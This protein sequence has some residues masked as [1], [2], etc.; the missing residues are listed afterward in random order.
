MNGQ[1]PF[2]GWSVVGFTF[3][4]Q[5]VAMGTL[6]YAYGPLLKP[7]T[8]A[9][10][11]DRFGVS[12]ALS[13]QTVIAALL[14]PWVGRLISERPIRGLM[15]WGAAFMSLGFFAMS[16]V[17]TLW[18]LYLSFGVVLGAAM[19]LL[20]PLPNNTLL[21]NWFVKRRGTAM[22]ISQFGV[23]L[24]GAVMV[25]VTSWMVLEYGWRAAPALFA[26][27]PLLVLV[28]LV[29]RFAVARPEDM[30]LAPDGIEV[31]DPGEPAENASDWTMTRAIGDRRI[32]LLVAVV[33]PSFM[34][35]GAVLMALH[36]HVTDLGLSAVQ[37][38][39]VVALTTLLA[40]VAKPLFGTLADH[41]NPRFVMTLSIAGQMAG[42][43]LIVFFDTFAG[44]LV[45]AVFF[46]LGYGA[47]MPMWSVLL[48]ALF[49]RAVFGRVMGLMGPLTTPFVLV[50]LPFT[51]WVFG[52]SGS[53]RGAFLA[54]LVGFV[55]SLVALFH[56]RLPGE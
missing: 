26:V 28:P 3:V 1:K 44:L 7:L 10:D 33:G 52:V 40:A 15:W 48:G 54:L 35:I 8:E 34:A 39:S 27:I 45:A 50:G 37:A 46:G 32:W 43:L 51:T 5:F 29:W 53:Y 23:S 9:L 19:A 18:Q 24:S 14:N 16:K 6:F 42:T 4:V 55:V 41:F 13:L 22:G 21:A 31:A 38:S 36:S 11:T 49:G 30:D 17:Q 47:V 20:G 56:L 12:L 2:F 25:P